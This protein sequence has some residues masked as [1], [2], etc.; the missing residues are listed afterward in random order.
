MTKKSLDEWIK[1]WEMAEREKDKTHR[2]AQKNQAPQPRET[3][4]DFRGWRIALLVYGPVLGIAILLA[5]ILKNASLSTVV[6]LMWVGGA[7]AGF[8]LLGQKKRLKKIASGYLGLMW[9][10]GGGCS[11]DLGDLLLILLTVAL[12]FALGPIVW[13]IA[14]FPKPG[15]E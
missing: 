4:D 10:S 14:L 11:S 7:I 9:G 2:G 6:A 15:D 13:I 3:T 12:P 1:H 5:V 8:V